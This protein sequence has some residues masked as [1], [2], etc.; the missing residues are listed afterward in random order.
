MGTGPRLGFYWALLQLEK[1]GA[2][3]RPNSVSQSCKKYKAGN[4]RRM[5]KVSEPSGIPN[6]CTEHSSSPMS[7][8][9]EDKDSLQCIFAS[10]SRLGAADQVFAQSSEG[11]RSRRLRHYSCCRPCNARQPKL[12][13]TR[14]PSRRWPDFDTQ[15][16]PCATFGPACGSAGHENSFEYPGLHLLWY[17][18]KVL[19]LLLTGHT[20][21]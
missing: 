20:N 1:A 18:A 10:G 2:H 9:T 17:L 21:I 16:S 14:R 4:I 15:S 13:S 11:N 7:R 6:L 12:H 19:H 5:G 3:E 8:H